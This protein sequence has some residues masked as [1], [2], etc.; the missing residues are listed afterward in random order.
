MVKFKSK[1]EFFDFSKLLVAIPINEIVRLLEK[2]DVRIPLYVHRFLVKETIRTEVFSEKLYNDYT[3][4]QKYRLRGY[5]NFSIFLLEKMIDDNNLNFDV[6]KYKE[7]LLNLIYLNKEALVIKD[8][9]FADLEQ[10]QHSYAVD[11][12]TLSYHNVMEIMNRI[13]YEQNGFLDGVEIS[14]WDDELLTSYTLGDLRA[15]G[16]KYGV[17]IP[18]R[19]N[20]TTLVE[21]L[22]HKFRLSDD[23]KEL[24]EMRSVLDLEIYAKE[25]GFKISIDLKKTD[26]IEFIKYSLGMYD[27]Y[28]KDDFFDYHI[29]LASD[30]EV[31]EEDI[32]EEKEDTVYTEEIHDEVETLPVEEIIEEEPASKT[33]EEVIEEEPEEPVEEVIEE[34][35]VE[36][37]TEEETVEE[38]IEEEPA[39]E[40][41]EPIVKEEP[42]KEEPE[43]VVEQEVEED[44]MPEEEPKLADASLLSP[45]EKELL[46]E[47]INL[48]IKKYYKKRR[49]RIAISIIVIILIL[50]VGGWAFYTYIWPLITG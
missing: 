19:I 15:L 33:T 16:T 5:D 30:E 45:E 4:E 31:V 49:R 32:I 39:K 46:D 34:E 9:F 17:K 22:T 36:E 48:I 23:E 13:L 10:L 35:P 27:H 3:D 12:E 50:A 1:E 28:P 41:P 6:A 42:V 24:L 38:V 47:K 44:I 29:P 21:M 25:N 14:E 43:A 40:E 20:K 26:M 2:F 8:N 37:V 7:M 11:M 18:R